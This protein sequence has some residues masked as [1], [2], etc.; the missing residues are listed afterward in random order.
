MIELLIAFLLSIGW[1]N[2]KQVD[3]VQIIDNSNGSYGVVSIDETGCRKAS[4]T[5]DETTGEW[6]LQ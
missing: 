3:E 1:L 5:Y 2:E 4:V 6:K